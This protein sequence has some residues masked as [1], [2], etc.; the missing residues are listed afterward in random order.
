MSNSYTEAIG[1]AICERLAAGESLRAICRSEG[2]PPESTVRLWAVSDVQ[3]FAAQ[4]TRAREAGYLRMADEITE[5]ADDG[6]GDTWTDDEGNV[7]TNNDVVARSRLRVDTRKWLLSKM[8]PKVYGDK[9][10]LT[11]DLNHTH[12]PLADIPTEE[13]RAALGRLGT[14]SE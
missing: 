7:R 10:E 8:L 1:A 12:R 11:G 2:M 3:G 5:I 13:L 6:T 4:Y 14:K 9:M